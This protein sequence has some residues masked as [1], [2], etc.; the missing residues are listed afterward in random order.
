ELAHVEEP[1]VHASMV[2]SAAAELLRTG[3]IPASVKTLNL[4]GEALPNPLAQGLYG[5]GTVEK[6]GNLYGPTEDTTYSTY[7]L[8][9]RGGEQVHVGR[10]VANTRTYVLDAELQPVPIG[11]IGELYLAGDGLSR[12]Y[13]RRP[14]LTAE[15]FVPNPFGAPGTRMYRVMDRVRWRAD[16]VLEYMGRTDFQVKV[17][18]F[19]IELGEIE[20]V[21]G[22]HPAVREVVAAVREDRPGDRRSVAYVTAR[23]GQ[24]LVP[25]ELRTHVGTH[26]PEYMVPSTVVVLEALPLTP[27]GKVDRR[28]LPAPEG[29]EGAAYV[30][31][32]DALELALAR[33]WEE[34]LGVAPVGVHDDFFALGGHSL[35]SVRLM[36]RVEELTGSRLPLATLF[37][38]P[39][40]GALASVLR[41]EAAGVGRGPL[42]PIRAGAG[43]RP[44]FLVHG[45]GGGVL[46]YAALG[47]RLP[48][49]QPL[50]GLQARG[51]DGGEAPHASIEAMAADYL[52]AVREI[53]P[54]GSYLLGGWSMGGVV[55]F[56]MS[57]QMEAAGERVERLVLVDSAFSVRTDD[58]DE[59]D[60]LAAFALHLGIPV[61]R[62]ALS[63]DMVRQMEP[64]ERLRIA[65]EAA[66]AADVVPPELDLVR[67][68]A[69]WDVFRANV[70]ALRRYRPATIEA[71]IVLVRAAEG[72]VDPTRWAELT[73]GR[74][75]ART[76]AGSHFTLVREPH[77][78]GLA[79]AISAAL[80]HLPPFPR[81]A[82]APTGPRRRS[83]GLSEQETASRGR[84][85][86]P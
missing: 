72:G 40:V 59:V 61:D 12:G 32:R 7:A 36:A 23:D 26:L 17:R 27:N 41:R 31:P 38:A 54:A 35:L 42:V 37:A 85:Y 53:Q 56:E 83:A 4:G 22:R 33:A 9:E 18:G 29:G 63:T 8:V 51:L 62:I 50:Y 79:A 43:R 16:G 76:V 66:R 77:V 46:S 78:R 15:R 47:R 80:T 19:R 44:L 30:A 24:A 3:G 70:A 13:A 82:A 11:V 68:H 28:A 75:E 60:L 69:L 74:V 71:D 21:L 73:T 65:L 48:P 10:P 45:A 64:G 58:Q 25:A 67:F 6:V 20:A 86:E 2:P 39:T 57:R 49:D 5:L 84:E 34:V 1:V 14:E 55:A 52:A 81:R